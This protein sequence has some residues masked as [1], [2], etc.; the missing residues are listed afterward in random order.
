MLAGKSSRD[1]SNQFTTLRVKIWLSDYHGEKEKRTFAVFRDRDKPTGVES[2]AA[3]YISRTSSAGLTTRRR[4]I[5]VLHGV[6]LGSD[7]IA[8]FTPMREGSHSRGRTDKK[9][10]N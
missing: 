7:V 5:V 10:M 1:I 4:T 2:V 8:C 3:L 6:D 9:R